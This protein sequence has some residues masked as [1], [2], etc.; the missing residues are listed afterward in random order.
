MPERYPGVHYVAKY[1]E[2]V[3]VG[4]RHYDA[5][6]IKPLFPFGYGLSY[7]TFGYKNLKITRQ[8]ITTD[9][10][11][12][13]AAVAELD[14]TNTGEKSG[15]AVV[16]LYV[17]LPSTEAVPQPPAQ[18]KAF[19]K[20][21]LQPGQTRHVRLKLDARSLSYWDTSAHGWAISPGQY[22]IM[23]G[24]SSRDLPLETS[25]QVR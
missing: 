19:D 3:F 16:E 4:Y 21:A 5:A 20:V 6:N 24:D 23:V 11:S 15:K 17:G 13:A 14:V 1:S 25:L 10:D 18:L 9:S 22:R 7:T 8:D 12:K 2:E